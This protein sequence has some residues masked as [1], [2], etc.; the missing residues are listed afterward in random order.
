MRADTLGP[1]LMELGMVAN[2][3]HLRRVCDRIGH[4]LDAAATSFAAV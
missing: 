2:G 4:I 3:Q 1:A